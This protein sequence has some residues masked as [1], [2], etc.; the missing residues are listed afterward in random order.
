MERGKTL[1]LKLY[2]CYEDCCCQKQRLYS[3]DC[4]IPVAF[5]AFDLNEYPEMA[6]LNKELFN[7]E[8]YVKALELGMKLAKAGY[9]SITVEQTQNEFPV[10]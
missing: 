8:E 7:A 1:N 9:T 10:K 2:E 3:T 4:E 5:L 6:T